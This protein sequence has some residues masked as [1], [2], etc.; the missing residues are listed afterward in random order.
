MRQSFT[1]RIDPTLLEAARAKAAGDNR[2]LT[3]YIETL[4]LRDLNVGREDT[5]EVIAPPDVRGYEPVRQAG[6]TDEQIK[7]R[8]DLVHA[9]L[10][11]S[12]H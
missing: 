2:S 9:I 1:M 11:A 8:R 3:N 6:E 12:G 10:D 4:M 7:L 5:L